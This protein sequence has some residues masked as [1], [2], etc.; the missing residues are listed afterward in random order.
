MESDKNTFTSG[1]LSYE[2]VHLLHWVCHN[3]SVM[4]YWSTPI[5]SV[6]ARHFLWLENTLL[7]SLSYSSGILHRSGMM[8]VMMM[9]TMMIVMMMMMMTIGMMVLVIVIMMMVVVMMK[10]MMIMMMMMMIGM[11][12]LVI[13]IMMMM[14]VVVM[15]MRLVDFNLFLILIM[16]WSSYSMTPEPI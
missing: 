13:V 15:M 10:V 7:R 5:C 4:Y 2:Y 3:S 6:E 1:H 11:M 14:L 12:M 16:I 9:M 8:I